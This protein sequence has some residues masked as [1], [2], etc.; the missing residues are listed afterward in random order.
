ML[1]K[2]QKDLIKVIIENSNKCSRF[3]KELCKRAVD[4]SSTM[5]EVLGKISFSLTI[6]E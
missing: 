3:K 6:K 1:S 2:E 4:E 5:E